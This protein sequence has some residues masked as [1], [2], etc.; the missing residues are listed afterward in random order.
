MR[1]IAL[2]LLLLLPCGV[3]AGDWQTLDAEG[4]R[5]A[6]EGRKVLYTSGAWQ[7]FRTSGRTLYNAGQD[8]WGYW[9]VEEGQYCS[10]WPPSDLWACYDVQSDGV[11]LRFVGA[12]GDVTDGVYAD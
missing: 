2:T 7:D 10:T 3:L 5:E 11:G 6:L 4:V 8:S 1:P 9:R 12:A